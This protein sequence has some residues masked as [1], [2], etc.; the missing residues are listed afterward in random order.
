MD[1]RDNSSRIMQSDFSFVNNHFWNCYENKDGA[2]VV[3][4][5]TAT[6]DYLNTYYRDVLETGTVNWAS[7]TAHLPRLPH[8][9]ACV[10]R[11]SVTKM[12]RCH[13][14]E[15]GAVSRR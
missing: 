13:G 8:L 9:R 11:D 1:R 14:K 3:D 5:V 12:L 7:K 15:E 4:S 6:E 2:V 10:F